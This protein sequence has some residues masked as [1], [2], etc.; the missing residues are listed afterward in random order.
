MKALYINNHAKETSNTNIDLIERPM[1]QINGHNECLIKIVSSGINPSDALAVKGYFKH[2]VIPRIPGR[3]FTGVV[4]DGPSYLIGKSVWGTG[5]AAGIDFDGTQAQYIK[6]FEHEMSEIPDNLDLVT[7]GVQPLPY[8]TA[9]YSL[10][11]RAQIKSNEAVLIV[12]ALGQVGSAAMSI[13]HWK[14]CNAIALVKGKNETEQAIQMG[15]NAINSEDEN[16]SEAILKANNGHKI[17]VILNSIGNIYWKDFLNSLSD[18]GRIVTIGARENTRETAI[19]L[20]DLYRA[21]QN[22]IGINTVSLNFSQNATLLN[23]LKIGFE[24]NKLIP[25]IVKPLKVYT[26][27]QANQAYQEV[28]NGTQNR[29]VIQFN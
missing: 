10:V 11:K 16:L 20:F 21:N 1:P 24:E 9:Y 3:D 2:A 23:E 8:V 26:M 22:I 27:E 28:I 7:A 19:N 15:W 18:F 6:L 12:G 14:Q 29:V 17:Q 5:G 4:I 25:R 13:C